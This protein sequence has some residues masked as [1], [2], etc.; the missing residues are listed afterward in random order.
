MNNVGGMIVC[1]LG[2]LC[3]AAGR[4]LCDGLITRPGERY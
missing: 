2:M 3:V 4:G 1:L